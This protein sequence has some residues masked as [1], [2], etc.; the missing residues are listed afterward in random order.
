MRL[1]MRTADRYSPNAVLLTVLL[2]LVFFLVFCAQLLW[3]PASRLQNLYVRSVVLSAADAVSAAASQT[4][5]DAFVP[6]ARELFLNGSGLASHTAWD[7]RYYNRRNPAESRSGTEMESIPNYLMSGAAVLNAVYESIALET[8]GSAARGNARDTAAGVAQTADQSSGFPSSLVH[9]PE[10]PLRV[11][12]FGDSQ[13]Y[14]LGNGLSRLSGKDG[15]I[16]VEVLAVHSTGFIR[17]DYYSWPAK[18]E[19]TFSAQRYDAAVLMLGMNDYQ[20]FYNSAGKALRKETAEWE[21]A[22]HERC[23]RIIDLLLMNVDRVYWL[24]MPVVQN[25]AYNQSLAYIDEVQQKLAAE[26]SP[27]T[28]QRISVRDVLPGTGKSFTDT[29]VREDGSTI[30]VMSSDGT[31]FT[32]EGGQ[33]VMR[34]LFDSLSRDFMFN[35]VPVAVMP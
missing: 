26:Y 9:S 8:A 20:N 5:L 7:T 24:G 25:S 33:L 19:D 12:A 18:L 30:K 35:Q 21:A 32:V 31:H 11:F 13:A 3:I 16:V 10:N 4:G 34:P 15:P 22:Y 29:V 17:G 1:T 23:R 27:Q 28:L 6:R 14:S 2:T